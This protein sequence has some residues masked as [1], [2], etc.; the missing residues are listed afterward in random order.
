VSRRLPCRFPRETPLTEGRLVRRYKRFLADVELGS[1]EVVTAHCANTGAM[2]GMTTPGARVWLSFTD[3]PKRKLSWTWELVEAERAMPGREAETAPA[4][5]GAH[6]SAP[7]QL[8]RR[9]LEERRLDWLGEWETLRPEKRYGESSRIDF[10]LEGAWGETYVEVKNCH[11]VYPDGRAYFPDAVSTRAAK[12]LAEL[13]AVARQGH[14]A[15]VLFV[16]QTGPVACLRPSDA[17]DPDFA[18]A[19]RQAAAAGVGFSALIVSH[20]PEEIV[21]EGLV[22]VDLEPYDLTEVARWREMA[23]G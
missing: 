20:T 11:L 4:L 10:W 17:H 18:A 6:T 1:G 2:E 16:A 22:P 21:V 9:L 15:E 5:F 12:H 19:A 7:N 14:R 23:R 8:V 3:D 13:E